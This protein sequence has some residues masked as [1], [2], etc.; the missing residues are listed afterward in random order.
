MWVL[1]C[2]QIRVSAV[3]LAALLMYHT[4]VTT[5]IIMHTYVA[6]IFFRHISENCMCRVIMRYNY[7]IYTLCN[8]FA[9]MI[10]YNV[11]DSQHL[12]TFSNIG[13]YCV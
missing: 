5:A 11:R 7:F 3:L 4:S 8:W 9:C 2:H 12:V 13:V 1:L 6:H 10:V